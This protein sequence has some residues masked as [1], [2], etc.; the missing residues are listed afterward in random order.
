[1]KFQF[2]LS[3]LSRVEFLPVFSVGGK[4]AWGV[5]VE[6]VLGQ[7]FLAH[8][9]VECFRLLFRPAEKMWRS[10][11]TNTHLVAALS[12]TSKTHRL[13]LNGLGECKTAF[14]ATMGEMRS[15][16]TKESQ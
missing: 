15:N 10:S 7:T 16:K 2:F 6:F 8:A 4:R 12:T 9:A 1:M 5:W 3:F 11:G 13:Q 14:T